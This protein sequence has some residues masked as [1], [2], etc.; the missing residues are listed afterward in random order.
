MSTGFGKKSAGGQKN[1]KGRPSSGQ[2]IGRAFRPDKTPRQGV[3]P[4]F[5]AIESTQSKED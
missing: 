4:S 2:G 1:G 3:R 5:S